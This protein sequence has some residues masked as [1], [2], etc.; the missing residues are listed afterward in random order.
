MRFLKKETLDQHVKEHDGLV[1]TKCNKLFASK[2]KVKEHEPNCD[3][4]KVEIKIEQKPK[5]VKKKQSGSTSPI[6]N[7]GNGKTWQCM[8]C[9]KYFPSGQ[10]LGGHR[11]SAHIKKDKV[12][13]IVNGVQVSKS[14][15]KKSVKKRAVKKK[16]AKKIK[17]VKKKM[18]AKK[19]KNAVEKEEK[20]ENE[21]N[22]EYVEYMT[23]NVM[24]C[25]YFIVLMTGLMTMMMLII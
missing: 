11:A 1:C 18:V 17:K 16:K 22:D 3:G 10:S 2:E 9:G 5:M 13:K 21:Q 25:L 20:N 19:D 24:Y 4:I 14:P 12:R 23:G 7:N 8:D 15:K 6:N